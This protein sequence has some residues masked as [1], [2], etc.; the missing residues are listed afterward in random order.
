MPIGKNDNRAVSTTRGI[1][2]GYAFSAPYGTALPTDIVTP[3]SDDFAC[4]GFISEDG[5]EEGVD[6]SSEIIPDMNGDIVDSYSE[7]TTETLGLTL[8]EMAMEAL[9]IQYGHKNV[10]E[11]DGILTAVHK[12]SD[13]EEQR[14]WVLELVLKNGRRWRK[15]I[16]CAK[17]TERDSFTGN[18]KNVTGRK[19]TLTYQAD[20]AGATCY[21]YIESI[22]KPTEE[23]PPAPAE[24]ALDDMTVDELKAYAAEHSIDIEGKTLKAD[25]L[26]AIK[27]A[28]SAEG[29]E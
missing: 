10:T 26:A 13:A 7:S 12:W 29:G 28:Q 3:L 16:P 11:E 18:S 24:K 2:G 21:D 27:A 4:V 9:A 1:K 6:G 15:V 17:V 5:W 14:S 25:I 20:D 23:E 22:D 8:I 19:V